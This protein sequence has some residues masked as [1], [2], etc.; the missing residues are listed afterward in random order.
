MLLHAHAIISRFLHCTLKGLI[1]R[2]KWVWM[3]SLSALGCP[4]S[5]SQASIEAYSYILLEAAKNKQKAIRVIR[6]VFPVT[7]NPLVGMWYW[8]EKSSENIRGW[9]GQ[10]NWHWEKDLRT[11]IVMAASACPT[12]VTI[13]SWV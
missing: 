1:Y 10:R 13:L 2:D 8:E 9:W 4:A 6:S 7:W 5:N 11:S 3:S 12:P